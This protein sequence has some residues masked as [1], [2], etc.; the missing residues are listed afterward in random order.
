MM[1]I[2]T[3]GVDAVAHKR[4]DP[5]NSEVLRE[6]GVLDPRGIS[7]YIRSI[8]GPVMPTVLQ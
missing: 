4:R 3:P 6:L 1:L 7:N 8:L 5:P 2:K